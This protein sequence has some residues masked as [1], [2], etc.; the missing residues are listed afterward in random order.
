MRMTD[1]L[2]RGT[3]GFDASEG[4][5]TT[6]EVAACFAVDPKTVSR[7]ARAAIVDEQAGRTPRVPVMRTPGGDWR[8]SAKWVR[9]Q[10]GRMGH[11]Q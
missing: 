3:V 8:F 5:L 6:V 2:P 11:G 7:W 10:L 1:G 4:L 9:E